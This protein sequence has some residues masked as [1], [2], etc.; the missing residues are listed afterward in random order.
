M[1]IIN[2]LKQLRE[3]GATGE[4][5]NSLEYAYN[6]EG[7]RISKTV[8]RE[9]PWWVNNSMKEVKIKGISK[10]SFRFYKPKNDWRSYE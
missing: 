5:I 7:Q 8:N 1:K 10:K 9:K 4:I 2:L 3:V 6:N